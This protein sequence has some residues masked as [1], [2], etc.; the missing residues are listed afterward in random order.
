MR[1]GIAYEIHIH[2]RCGGRRQ[3]TLCNLMA[4]FWDVQGDRVQLGGQ[5]VRA[6]SFDG[7]I[8]NF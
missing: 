7:L 3:N 6:Y 8:R 5:D 2:Q 4:R 1:K